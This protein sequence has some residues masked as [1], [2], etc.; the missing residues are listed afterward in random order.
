MV[1]DGIDRIDEGILYVLQQNARN[2]TT[3]DIGELVGVSSSTVS[4]RIHSLEERDV[5]TGYHPTI[6]YEKAGLDHHLLVFATV[7]FEA[8]EQLIDDVIDVVGVVS[9]REMLTNN[10]NATIEL[11]GH[12][13]KEIQRSL[14][15]IDALG[16]EIERMD[17]V[18]REVS[19]PYDHFGREFVNESES[20]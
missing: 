5:I 14:A 8:Q 17:M 12:N 11:V 3:V 13:R 6:D 20:G 16:V 1:S 4:N 9:V 19:Q 7:P 18:N 10:W 2:N 15:H